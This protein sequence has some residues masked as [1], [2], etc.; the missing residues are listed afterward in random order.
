MLCSPLLTLHLL[1][2]P[3]FCSAFWIQSKLNWCDYED[4]LLKSFLLCVF[5]IIDCAYWPVL[6]PLLPLS[7]ILCSHNT[8]ILFYYLFCYKHLYRLLFNIIPIKNIKV[9]SFKL[10]EFQFTSSGVRSISWINIMMLE[11]EKPYLVHVPLS[12]TLQLELISSSSQ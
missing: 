10:K 8:V 3:V 7:C 11:A 12:E 6:S 4:L 5:H 9:C 2:F 1:L